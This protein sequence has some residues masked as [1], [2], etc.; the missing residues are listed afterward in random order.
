[1]EDRK[2]QKLAQLLNDALAVIEL[3][4]SN[5][6][7]VDIEDHKAFLQ[8]NW[9][10]VDLL[11]PCGDMEANPEIKDK[12]LEKNL[13]EFIRDTFP[14]SFSK[15]DKMMSVACRLL[16]HNAIGYSSKVFLDHLLNIV[17]CRGIEGAVD[18]FVRSTAK[19]IDFKYVALLDGFR[20]DTDMQVSQGIQLL[21]IPPFDKLKSSPYLPT[22]AIIHPHSFVGK[23]L[24]VVD[25]RSSPV[26]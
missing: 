23:T 5:N 3:R 8:R 9:G 19:Y 1:M 26:F 6:L 24:L 16:G 12:C 4:D 14:K 20:I 10:S 22:S 11:E 7:L 21:T 15:D 18:S 17:I 25:V 2:K 13:L